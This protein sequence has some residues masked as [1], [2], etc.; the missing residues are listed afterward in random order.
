MYYFSLK[1]QEK[2]ENKIEAILK[3]PADTLCDASVLYYL[4][5]FEVKH[6]NIV[7]KQARLES[8]NYLS[9]LCVHSNNIFG[10]FDSTKR[11]YYSFDH[12][13]ESIVVYKRLV[14]NKYTGGCYYKF[15]EQLPYAADAE[16]VKKL[17][18]F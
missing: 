5:L 1:M 14:Q 18:Q 11:N 9:E 16:Y 3:T 7:L 13:V 4:N 6:P 17:K 2:Y 8:G 15:L 10:L 12:W